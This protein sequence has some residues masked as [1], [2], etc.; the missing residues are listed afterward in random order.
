MVKHIVFILTAI[1]ICSCNRVDFK[2]LFIPTGDGVEKRFEQSAE[3]NKDLKAGTVHI[4]GSYIFYVAADPHINTTHRN[5]TVFNGA[6]RND[7]G[8]AFGVILGDCIDVRD[9][10]PKYME[11]LAHDPTRHAYDH[12]LF[13]LLG[14][15]DVFFNGWDDFKEIV[16]PSVYW[17]EVEAGTD[18][19]LYI[20]LDTATGTLGRKQSEWLRTFLAENRQSYRHC[21][22]MTHTNFFYT[23]NSQTGS[24]N[25]PI[26]ECF[27]LIDL[28]G[29]HDVSLVLQGHDHYREDLSYN[30]V[31]YVVLGTIHDESEAPEYL[32]VEVGPDDIQLDWQ[33]RILPS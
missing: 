22:I 13:H 30:G 17:F 27:S 11:A 1:A 33:T 4:E 8:A 21:I 32:K 5:L 18:R 29:R 10:L 31:R 23:D 2:G 25:L 6:F 24:G 9:N 3:M 20:T 19:D 16:G 26:E 12:E 15:H 28:L 7:A 14:N